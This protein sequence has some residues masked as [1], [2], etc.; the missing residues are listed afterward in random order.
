V[1]LLLWGR[2]LEV[3]RISRYDTVCHGHAEHGD[4]RQ[5]WMIQDEDNDLESDDA[6]AI[7]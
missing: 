7:Q 6:V 1:N 5:R 2:I 3:A 4:S